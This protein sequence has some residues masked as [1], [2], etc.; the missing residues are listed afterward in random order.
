MKTKEFDYELP[1]ELI[2]KYPS[3]KRGEDRLM[4]LERRFRRYTHHQFS[5]LPDLIPENSLLVFNNSRV[6]K[7]RIYGVD[8]LTKKEIEFLLVKQLDDAAYMW[9]AMSKN[10]KRK[11]CGTEYYFAENLSAHIT[12]I[13]D[14]FVTLKFNTA[15]TDVWLEKNG[16]IPLPPYIKRDDDAL[17]SERYQTVYAKT[18]GSSAAPT[19]GL[20]FTDDMLHQLNARNIETVFVTLH[21]G[22]GT[23]LPVYAENIEEHKMH[24]EQYTISDDAAEK[25]ERAKKAERKV[26]AV[27]TTSLRTLESAY[28]KST[29]QLRRGRSQTNIFIYPPYNFLLA[30]GLF[31]NFHT[32]ESTLLMLASAFAGKDFIM[33][34]YSEAIREK[35]MFFSYGDAM[36]IL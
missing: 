26:I 2:A 3:Q 31:T 7:A 5:E 29:N 6:R 10:N 34:A 19:A 15:V 22:L 33:E 18:V 32:P 9:S 4:F 23:F 35:Y 1:T 25:I 21:V 11:K 17:D 36:L 30:D 8:V 12:N 14:Q 20:H 24:E 16:H 28:N 27:G 13:E